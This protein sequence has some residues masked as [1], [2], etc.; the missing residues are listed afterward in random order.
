MQKPSIKTLY[1]APVE[2]GR[3]RC[4]ALVPEAEEICDTFQTVLELFASCHNIYDSTTVDS[5]T[6]ASLSI[7]VTQCTCPLALTATHITETNIKGFMA[8]YRQHFPSA[9]VLPKMHMLECHVPGW[10]EK[11]SVGL[12]LIG[13]QGAESIHTSFNTIEQSYWSMPNLVD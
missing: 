6:I 8:F 10:M 3:K 1:S 4:S 2:V 5:T 11:W 7:Q 13:E 12:G 9:T